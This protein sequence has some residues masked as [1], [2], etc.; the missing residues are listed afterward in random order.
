M[1]DPHVTNKGGGASTGPEA[2]VPAWSGPDMERVDGLT[3]LDFHPP[4][5]DLHADVERGLRGRTPGAA[6]DLPGR[7]IP[8]KWFY[9]ERGSA[10]FDA[11]TELEAYYPTRAELEITRRY[12]DEIAQEIGPRPL[13]VEYGSGSSIKTRVLLDHLVEPVA[14][15]PIDISRDHLLASAH[16][17]AEEYPTLEI[18]PICADYTKP[19]TIPTPQRT[20]GRRVIYFPGSTIGNFT[21]AQ[22]VE[23]LRV[24]AA[25]A[26]VAGQLLIGVD[27]I[28]DE[29]V[30]LPAYDDPQGVTA[31]FNKNLLTRI[32]RELKTDFDPDAFEHRAA[33]RADEGL[34][35]G[36]V[37]M[38]LVSRC[39][40]TV[41]LD[42]EAYA[43]AEGEALV[44]EYSYK[45]A[46]AAFAALA[47]EAGWS[48]RH[49]WTDSEGLFSVQ[50]L[51]LVPQA[52]DSQSPEV[53]N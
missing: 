44:T 31:A 2:D 19:L 34:A 48:V 52:R 38:H 35:R 18:L 9:D 37:E 41:H 28:K 24:A 5:G 16:R 32:N 43:F 26:G 20:P 4:M 22:A 23:F 51:D 21:P 7:R 42:G 14:Y 8:P 47:A 17:L 25:E 50:L 39:A 15:V 27:L 13:V 12:G 36:R 1:K 46:P 3:L 45:Y 6:G 11:I 30:L 10:L 49:L 40:Q 33:W 29:S 53:M